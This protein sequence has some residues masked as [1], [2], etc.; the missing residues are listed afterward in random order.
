MSKLPYPRSSSTLIPCAVRSPWPSHESNPSP[1][2]TKN[3]SLPEDVCS[4]TASDRERQAAYDKKTILKKNG[5]PL[6]VYG[7]SG[8][9]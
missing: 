2:Y 9:G 1:L 6:T 4:G 5:A 3:A 7:R 8:D